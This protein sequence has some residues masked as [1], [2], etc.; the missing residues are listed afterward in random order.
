MDD[1]TLVKWFLDY[2]VRTS[3]Q[4]QAS[5]PESGSASFRTPGDLLNAA[6]RV[7]STAVFDVLLSHGATREKSIPLHAAAG[8]GLNGERTAM[9]IHLIE[10]GFEVNQTDGA[11]GN[12][13]IGTPLQYA[14]RAKCFENVKC[15]LDHGADPHKPVGLAGS[16]FKTAER[17]GAEDIFALLKQYS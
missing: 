5:D 8:A 3:P 16:A 12:F 1:E 4:R 14:I 17:I 11:M 13:A 6:G 7:S 10:L 2:V 15:L 9:I